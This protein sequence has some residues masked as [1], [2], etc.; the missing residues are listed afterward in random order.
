MYESRTIYESYPALEKTKINDTTSLEQS[1]KKN[2]VA[3]DCHSMP[4]YENQEGCARDY[5]E[6]EAYSDFSTAMSPE[7]FVRGAVSTPDKSNPIRMLGFH[8]V[9]RQL[10]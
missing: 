9:R 4:L 7:S 1:P 10:I 6:R 8:R 5:A 3:Y 2:L